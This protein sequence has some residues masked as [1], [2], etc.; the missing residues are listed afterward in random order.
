M[1]RQSLRLQF[2]VGR[3]NVTDTVIASILRRQTMT[4]SEIKV[5]KDI[6]DEL[7]RIRRTLEK[8]AGANDD[9]NIDKQGQ[10]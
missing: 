5:F 2:Q 6:A 1:I 4:S 9:N 7:R 3:E 8:I 10:H